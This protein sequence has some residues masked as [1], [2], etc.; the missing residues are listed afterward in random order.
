MS[1]HAKTKKKKRFRVMSQKVKVFRS[2]NPLLSVLMWGV[3]HSVSMISVC[4]FYKPFWLQSKAS[5]LVLFGRSTNSRMWTI[6]PCWCLMTSKRSQ[7]FAW[8]IISSTSKC[9]EELPCV[10]FW[11]LLYFSIIICSVGVVYLPWQCLDRNFWVSVSFSWLS[12]L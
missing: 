10:Y 6:Q 12:L 4:F 5:A 8:T 7:N 3:S 1:S 11:I 9:F 2:K